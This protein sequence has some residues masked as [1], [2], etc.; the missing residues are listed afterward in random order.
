MTT[1]A[2]GSAAAQSS[3]GRAGAARWFGEC[4]AGAAGGLAALA[5]VLA[6]GLLANTALGPE[7]A[8]EGIPASFIATVFGGSLYAMLARGPMPAGGPASAP[9][10]ILAGLVMRIAGDSE[11]HRGQPADVAALLSLTAASVVGMG[12]LQIAFALCGLTRAAKYVPHPVLAGFMNG[13]A[14][15]FVISQ[16]PTLLG[17]SGGAWTDQH[18]GAL[19]QIQPATFAIGV[20]TV[21][22]IWSWPLLLRW[23]GMPPFARYFPGAFAGLVVGCAAYAIVTAAWPR[24]HLGGVIGFVPRAWPVLDRLGPL[25]ATDST[26]LLHRYA[27]VTTTTA[28]LMALIGTLDIVLNG[29][30]LDQAVQTRTEPRRELIALGAGNVLSGALGGLPLLLNRARALATWRAGGR[31]RL[32]LLFGNGLYALLALAGTSLLALLPKVVLGG[33][34]IMIGLL[35]FDGWSFR[36][37]AQWLRGSRSRETRLDLLLVAIVCFA[38][39]VWGFAIGVAIGAALA[40][41]LFIRS[42]NRSLIRSRRS[43]DEMP[44]RRIYVDAH[45][46][47]LQTVRPSITILELEGAL[48]FGSADRLVR[49]VDAL[50]VGCRTI[51]LDLHRISLVDASGAMVLS[52]IHRRLQD[53]GVALLLAGLAPHEARGQALIEFAGESLPTTAWHPD[54]DRAVEDAELEALGQATSASVDAAVPLSRSALMNGLD[55]AQCTRLAACLERLDLAAGERLFAQGDAGDRLFVLTEGSISVVG[56]NDLA[57][58]SAGASRVRYVT[59][60]PGMMF[61]EVAML[62]HRGR[63]A[64]AVADTASVVHALSE[65][66]L[67]VLAVEEP[68]LAALVYRNIAVHL[69]T[70]LRIASNIQ[71]AARRAADHGHPA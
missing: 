70:R 66:Q 64:E 34:M 65:A 61:G 4:V 5:A 58:A 71:I 14:L 56:G 7:A 13:V 28:F 16:L 12:V 35:L 60:S 48:F 43:G 17:W 18:W 2:P 36:L 41:A 40:V 69:S 52:Q 46:A 25:F 54:V 21:A 10:L 51:V 62:D 31:T 47:V 9:T 32:S 26:G 55:P 63:S 53:R 6:L 22:M 44:S 37:A 57:T 1:S 30:A 45:E 67:Q 38:S 42:M 15:T 59:C 50:G 68:P 20:L 23:R 33:I 24:A 29:L 11:F 3:T 39:V 27:G 19:A 8:A 49:E